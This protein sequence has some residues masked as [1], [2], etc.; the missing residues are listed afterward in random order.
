MNSQ[1]PLDLHMGKA[2]SRS[3]VLIVGSPIR[4]MF[5][6]SRES[7]SLRLIELIEERGGKADFHDP[8]VNEIPATRE[9]IALKGRNSVEL[10]ETALNDFDAVLIA[11]DHDAVDY[12]A[13][14][15]WA[16][17]IVDTRNVFTRLG[18][19]HHAL[20]KA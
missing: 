17:L 3:R 13:I 20:V 5:P 11:T 12:Q 19:N 15:N 4:R 7:P 10:T 8:H 1:K 6:I 16:P 2:L 18:L 14:A 9:H